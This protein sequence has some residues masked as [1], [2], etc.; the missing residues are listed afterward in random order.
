MMSSNSRNF[1]SWLEFEYYSRNQ[2]HKLP[3]LHQ[4]FSFVLHFVTKTLSILSLYCHQKD[5][6]IKFDRFWSW[7]EFQ[8]IIGINIISY[9][10][11]PNFGFLIYFVTIISCYC[12]L[13]K[14]DF[15][16]SQY[17]CQL[18]Q[19]WCHKRNKHY[20]ILVNTEFQLRTLLQYQ[21]IA[22][23]GKQTTTTRKSYFQFDSSIRRRAHGQ[24]NR[25]TK[26][27]GD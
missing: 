18:I 23:S 20:K 8:Q 21:D 2:Y 15:M 11:A 1:D 3:L 7:F 17:F 16:E 12:C 25:W 19:I 26:N 9:T 4:N 13:Q 27:S 10:Y 22:I 6:V 24:W 5:D 14:D